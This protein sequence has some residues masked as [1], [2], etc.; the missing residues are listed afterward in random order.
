[1]PVKCL[2]LQPRY[3][4]KEE[5]AQISKV[6]VRANSNRAAIRKTEATG[7]SHH[8]LPH[9]G[10]IKAPFSSSRS[11]CSVC[12]RSSTKQAT[13]KWHPPQ[14]TAFSSSGPWEAGDFH[15]CLVIVP[16]QQHNQGQIRET[17]WISVTPSSTKRISYWGGAC[18]QTQDMGD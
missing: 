13:I 9:P 17:F 10:D 5:M 3:F 6:G 16:S 4:V 18:L 1:M 8:L 12:P 7:L 2:S 11:W 15:S 14:Y